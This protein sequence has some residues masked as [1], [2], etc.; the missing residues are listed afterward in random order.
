MAD[1][2]VSPFGKLKSKLINSKQKWA[3]DG[4]LLTG[5]D[6]RACP[7]PAARPA[8]GR[9]LTVLDLRIQPE[10]PTHAWRLFVDGT[11]GHPI[12]EVGRVHRP[13]PDHAHQRQRL[14]Q[15]ASLNGSLF[16]SNRDRK[17][18]ASIGSWKQ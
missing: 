15:L 13:A 6:G 16:G 4:R 10:I 8:Q 9:E 3:E 5:E 18:A 7:A 17:I 12:L 2:D 14:A 1:D 11:G